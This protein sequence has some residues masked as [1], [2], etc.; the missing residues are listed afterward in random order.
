MASRNEDIVRNGV[1]IGTVNEV[2]YQ[3]QADAQEYIFGTQVVLYDVESD[4]T[5]HPFR[6]NDVFRRTPKHRAVA[7]AYLPLE[8]T[9]A[10]AQTGRTVQGLNEFDERQPDR[11]NTWVDFRVV[12]DPAGAPGGAS[13]SPWLLTKT[14]APKGYSVNAVG[15]RLLNSDFEHPKHEAYDLFAPC[16]QP[17]GIPPGKGD[18]DDAR[19]PQR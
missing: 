12:V 3:S 1:V 13:S 14:K 10:L 9:L 15:L 2:V 19:V 5:G 16:Y 17:N 7:T 11:D 18:D 8:G 6:A 4:S